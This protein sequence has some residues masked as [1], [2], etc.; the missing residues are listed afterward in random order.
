MVNTTS[1]TEVFLSESVCLGAS[2]KTSSVSVPTM[3]SLLG[4]ESSKGCT[5]KCLITSFSKGRKKSSSV[6]SVSFHGV[7][8]PLW[9]ISSCQCNVTER[10]VGKDTHRQFWGIGVAGPTMALAPPLGE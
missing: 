4:S 2:R 3:H 5:G 10:V 9:L 1:Y 7:V 6:E 8:L